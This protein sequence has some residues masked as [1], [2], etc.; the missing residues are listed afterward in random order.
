MAHARNGA[1]PVIAISS[2]LGCALRQ[3]PEEFGN[4]EDGYR[5]A[6]APVVA[7]RENAP[8][9]R[10]WGI[11][12]ASSGGAHGSLLERERAYPLHRRTV[13]R[14]EAHGGHA[15]LPHTNRDHA[16]HARHTGW[17]AGHAN[18]GVRNGVE[19]DHPHERLWIRDAC[20]AFGNTDDQLFTHTRIVAGGSTSSRAEWN[21]DQ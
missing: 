15:G 11:R 6:S 19:G 7:G 17:R 1:E 13:V 20:T 9:V 8:P 4:S 3:R 5:D 10:R 16:T 2:E 21:L 14:R 12:T 18:S